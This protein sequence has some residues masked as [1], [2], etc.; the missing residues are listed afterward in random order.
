MRDHTEYIPAL[1]L[2]AL[3][4]IY[5]SV[6]RRLFREAYIKQQLIAA[7]G[8][9]PGQHILDLGCGTGTLMLMLKQGQ[10]HSMVTGVDGD[11]AVLGMA[12]TKAAH[13]A[14]SVS[15][16]QAFVSDLPYPDRT[17]DRVLS[18]LVFHHL[19]ASAKRV[20]LREIYRVLRVDGELHLLDFGA[21]HTHLG[22]LA[23]PLLRHLEQV[24]DNLDGL[25][26]IMVREAGFAEVTVTNQE[27]V[28][29]VAT[30]TWLRA[31]KAQPYVLMCILEAISSRMVVRLPMCERHRPRILD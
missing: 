20:A 30:V 14:H 18:S 22:R 4:P 10:P 8:I 27:T 21:P 29:V 15:F 23:A 9:Q 6:L 3:T 7:A 12:R 11:V 5:D 16:S 17:F 2:R 1:G 25:I 13:T 26:P 24:A 19:S 31:R 28:M